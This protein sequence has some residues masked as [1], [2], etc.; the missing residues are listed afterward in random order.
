MDLSSHFYSQ[1][2]CY[3]IY[4]DSTEG[5]DLNSG[6]EVTLPWKTLHKVNTSNFRPGDT[7]SLQQG[8][9]WYEQLTPPSSGDSN[10]PIVITSY[11]SGV[12]PIINGSDLRS[13]TLYISGKHD[14]T[15]SNI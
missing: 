5:N 12:K 2:I 15:I 1:N 11:G 3:N 8:K 9:I 6:T 14:I 7:I 10:N 13:H 4:V